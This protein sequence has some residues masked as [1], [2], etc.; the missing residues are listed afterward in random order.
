MKKMTKNYPIVLIQCY[1]AYPC[2]LLAI[3]EGHILFS[4]IS[5]SSLIS[6]IILLHVFFPLFCSEIKCEKEK[7]NI[8]QESFYGILEYKRSKRAPVVPLISFLTFLYVHFK[9]MLIYLFCWLLIL[10]L[11]DAGSRPY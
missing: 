4:L 5:F 9:F 11:V 6:T 8:E 7:N 10:L 1:G 2:L 3:D